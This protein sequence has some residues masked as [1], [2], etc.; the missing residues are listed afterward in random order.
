MGLPEDIAAGIDDVSKRTTWNTPARD[1]YANPTEIWREVVARRSQY[2][3]IRTKLSNGEIDDINALITYN[4]DIRQFAQDVI[5]NCEGPDLLRAVWKAITNVTIL[6]PTCGSGAFLFAALNILEPLYEACLDRMEIFLEELEYARENP[7][8]E[9]FRD[10][11]KVLENIDQHPNRRYFIL[12]SIIINNLYGVDIMEEA[13]EICKLRLFL[14]MVAQIEEVEQIEPLPD[15]DFNVQAGN[16]LVG[17]AT[18]DEVETAVTE[19]RIDFDN[20]MQRIEEQAEDVECLFEQFRRQQTELGGV[21]T[22]DDRQMLRNRLKALEDELNRYLGEEYGIDPSEESAYQNWLSSHKPFHW[23]IDFYGILK[24]GG[25]DVIIGNP[26]YVEY[27]TVRR[28]YIV[29][30]SELITG[31]NLHSMI[32]YRSFTLSHDNS[33]LSLIVPI[34][35]PSTERM[36]NIRK[37]LINC[38]GIWV[39]NYAIRPSKLFTG[40]EQRLSIFIASRSQKKKM[41]TTKYIKWNSEERNYLFNCLRYHEWSQRKTLRDVW[42]KFDTPVSEAI[43]YRVAKQAISIAECLGNTTS[44]ALYYKNTGIGYYIVV[45]RQSPVCYIN[46]QRSSSSRETTLVLMNQ[47]MLSVVHCVLNSS[48][49]FLVYQQLSNCRDLNPSDIHT[50]R[51]PQSLLSEPALQNLSEQL[52]QSLETNS[53]FQT[54]H[55][56]QTGEVRIQ[57]FTPSLSKSIIDEIDRVLAQHYD[58]TGEEL[59]FIINYDIKYRMGL[60]GE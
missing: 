27:N 33:Y 2:K 44:R 25:F 15:I 41:L 56:R 45:T 42:P 46:D 36:M 51:L 53:W 43:S 30:N 9:K 21:V 37:T 13:I 8:T 14:K 35:L 50:F 6:D 16:T 3:S 1:K 10:F 17:Y 58:L 52:Q 34:A 28:T 32:T 7:R 11:R 5:E 24:N 39:S 54:R 19:N 38:A 31:G 22:P 59:D 23:F 20:I 55:Q 57:S 60:G 18:Y 4:L 12:K 48:L 29:Q 47:Q 49:F 40:A 26:P